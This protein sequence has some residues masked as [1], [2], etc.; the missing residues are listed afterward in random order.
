MNRVRIRSHNRSMRSVSLTG[1][2]L[3]LL[4]L[5]L[6]AGPARAQEQLL[7]P[8]VLQSA[9]RL[10]ITLPQSIPANWAAFPRPAAAPPAAGAMAPWPTLDWTEST[11]AAQ[12]MTTALLKQSRRYGRQNGARGMAVFRNGYLVGEWYSRGWDRHTKQK[13]FSVAKSFTSG[14]Y[15]MMLQ[16]GSISDLDTKVSVA[17]PA[18]GDRNHRDADLYDLLSMSSGIHWS[19][20]EDYVG[21]STAANQNCYSAGQQLDYAPGA[22]WTY[23]NMGVQML[24][25]FL[26]QRL[27][28]QP[29]E[30]A[31]QKL[32]STIGMWDAD[33]I[34]DLAGN[35]L[36]YQSVKANV[37]ELGK[38]GYLFLRN[39][40]WDGQQ[41]IPASYVAQASAPSQGINPFY[42]L[43]FWLNTASLDMPDVPSDAYY[44]VGLF[45]KRIY[46]VPSLDLV[47]V[48]LGDPDLDWD[49]NAFLGP[50]CQACN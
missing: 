2:L 26:K 33:W 11:P 32:F 4:T 40:E 34:T 8:E 5:A 46:I 28:Q 20:F 6:T 13:T 45:E 36:T 15:G 39:G 14:L 35:T 27:G 24:G 49:D 43:L 21:L 38:F 42:G 29:H 31:Q 19:A 41:L 48:R 16:D 10:G 25:K 17:V 12:N 9:Q 47:V 30:F 7:P 44:A 22:T 1:P 18:W 37:R 50:I 23:S 3:A